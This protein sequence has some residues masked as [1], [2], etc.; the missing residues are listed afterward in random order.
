MRNLE[1]FKEERYDAEIEDAKYKINATSDQE[2]M[3][4]EHPDITAEVDKLLMKMAEAEDK[5]AANETTL[6]RKRGTEDF[7]IRH[8]GCR[9]GVDWV[10]R[11]S[12]RCR[13][14]KVT[15]VCSWFGLKISTLAIPLR[16]PCEGGG[17]VEKLLCTNTYRSILA[18][19]I[20]FQFFFF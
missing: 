6:W 18:F 16:Y 2:L 1:W 4:P 10:S 7:I 13:K 12:N 15:W 9:L 5:L 20:P 14:F 19:A 3:I 11:V 17:G 8:L